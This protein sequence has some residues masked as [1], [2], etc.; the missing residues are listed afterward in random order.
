MSATFLGD[1]KNQTVVGTSLVSAAARN[2]SANGTGVDCLLHDGPLHIF[3]TCGA[4]TG[5]PTSVVLTVEESDASGSGYAAITNQS[6]DGTVDITAGS[7]A[8]FLTLK[9]R[10]K[11]YV[12]V[13]ATLTGGSSPTYLATAHV[14]GQKKILGGNGT[15]L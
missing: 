9:H 14:V 12:R 3:Y 4:V 8:G 11:R 5:S 10:S 13:V 2:A 6:T 7:V 1:L 15:Q